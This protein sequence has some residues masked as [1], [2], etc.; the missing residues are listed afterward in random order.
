MLRTRDLILFILVLFF[1]VTAITAT[2]VR[3][4]ATSSVNVVAFNDADI[5]SGL[6]ATASEVVLDRQSVI[7]RL[8]SKLQNSTERIEPSASVEESPEEEVVPEDG[9]GL[10]RCLYPDDALA[11]VPRWPLS[12]VQVKVQEGA[13]AVFL[14]ET[15]V[16]PTV[17]GGTASS[18]KSEEVITT[19][20]PLLQLPIAPQKQTV[21]ACVPSE[22][23]GVTS[24]G[25]LMFNGDVNSYRKISEQSLIGYARDGFPIYGVYEGEV[26]QCG[27]YE[28]LLGYRYT[29]STE[30][31]YII[32]C[33][34]GTPAKFSL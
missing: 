24:G 11:M 30:R 21:S 8:R 22:V 23:V 28:H 7:D 5:T 18:T 20:T 2:V 19:I 1:L 25:I 14:I 29:I 17:S 9:I 33:Y 27:G 31:D 34:V 32:G 26:D 3:S 6:E 12:G 13:R 16:V 10:Q 4:T 15:A